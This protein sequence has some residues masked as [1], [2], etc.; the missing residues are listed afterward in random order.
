MYIV[1]ETFIAKPGRAGELAQLMKKE[2]E[3]WKE[4]KGHVLLDMVT[5]YNK[6][7]V[8]YE[9]KS[10]AEFEKMMTDYK[11]DQAKSKSKKPPK[12]TEL[13]QTGGREIYRI[14]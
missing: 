2:M 4:F 12:Y 9:I 5:D 14:V 13:Y 6:I 3:N 8:E 7:V 1:R 11:K 10:L